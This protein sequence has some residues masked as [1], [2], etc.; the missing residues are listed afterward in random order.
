MSLVTG[1]QIA[2]TVSLFSS[3]AHAHDSLPPAK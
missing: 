1:E 2:V 3:A